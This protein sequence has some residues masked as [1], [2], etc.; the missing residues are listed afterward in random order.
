M[1][2]WMLFNRHECSRWLQ[3]RG[4]IHQPLINA[5]SS[6]DQQKLINVK[7]KLISV[8]WLNYSASIF[9]IVMIYWHLFGWLKKRCIICTWLML[10]YI[11]VII[12]NV[13]A[14]TE[15]SSEFSDS[16]LDMSRRRSRRSQKKRV[17][18]C[19]TSESEG[20]QAETNRAKMKPRHQQD[21]SDSE[22]RSQTHFTN[23]INVQV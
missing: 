1:L 10:F 20:S 8:I 3:T 6:A 22:G 14:V 2:H 16:D 11:W 23:W 9:S 21:S 13:C 4:S 19:E 7:K 5:E 18:Y 12:N 15:G 17:N